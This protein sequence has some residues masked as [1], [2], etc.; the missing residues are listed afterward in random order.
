MDSFYGTKDEDSPKQAACGS[1]SIVLVLVC[2]IT[3]PLTNKYIFPFKNKLIDF[4]TDF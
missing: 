4:K 3:I 2:S 1:V